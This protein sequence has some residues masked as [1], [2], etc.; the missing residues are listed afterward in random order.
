MA[1]DRITTVRTAIR[2]I[3]DLASDRGLVLGEIGIY[4]TLHDA[5][6]KSINL[7]L[8]EGWIAEMHSE[9][10]LHATLNKV[11]GEE[12]ANIGKAKRR[13]NYNRVIEEI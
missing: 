7:G 11:I 8:N 4:T 9:G 10:T 6:G 1:Q 12:F 5:A 13:P 3:E 2:A